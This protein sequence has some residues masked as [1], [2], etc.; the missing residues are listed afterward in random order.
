MNRRGQTGFEYLATHGWVLFIIIVIFAAF[1]YLV[2]R[3]DSLFAINKCDMKTG[4][5]C[6][7]FAFLDSSDEMRVTVMNKLG[8]DVDI[9]D[10]LNVTVRGVS[11]TAIACG[12]DRCG[13]TPGGAVTWK[14]ESKRDIVVKFTDLQ[15]T[16]RPVV[17]I[18][19]DYIPAMGQYRHR[20]DAS[21]RGRVD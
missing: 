6:R 8:E 11:G 2:L 16:D 1:A 3:D 10:G 4:F 21:V 17:D 9:I 15:K 19:W 18:A 12:A 7:S 14:A 20:A 5:A 13:L